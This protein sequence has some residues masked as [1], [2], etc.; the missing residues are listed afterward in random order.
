VRHAV[1][2]KTLYA[3]I[4]PLRPGKQGNFV[5]P[6][7]SGISGVSRLGRR[8]ASQRTEVIAFRFLAQASGVEAASTGR[9]L[10]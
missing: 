1:K 9:D 10:P 4:M 7:N 5:C 3:G 2:R 6:A 8:R